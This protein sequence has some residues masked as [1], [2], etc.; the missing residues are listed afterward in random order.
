MG[1]FLHRE[2]DKVIE[3]KTVCPQGTYNDGGTCAKVPNTYT[4]KLNGNGATSGN[5][6][7]VS[8][9]T[10]EASC[11]VTLPKNGFSKNAYTFAKWNTKANGTGTSYKNAATIALNKNITLYAQ[12]TGDTYT[13]TYDSNGLGTPTVTNSCQVS[14]GK[15]SCTVPA[16]AA[17]V[18]TPEDKDFG[19]WNSSQD[20]SGDTNY[21]A[22]DPI[23]L[24]G[25]TTLYANWLGDTH[26]LTYNANGVN[27]LDVDDTCQVQG[28][29]DETECNV[30]AK[31]DNTFNPPEGKTFGVW[32]DN[33]AGIGETTYYPGDAI[34]LLDNNT[35]L[36]AIWIGS[37][38]TVT[39]NANEAGGTAPNDDTCIVYGTA[40]EDTCKVKAPSQGYL[41]TPTDPEK[42]F[43]GWNLVPAGTGTNYE[44][45]EEIPITADTT[46]YANWKGA[47]YT[48]TYKPNGVE[49]SNATDTC[50]VQGQANATTCTVTA[51]PDTTFAAPTDRLLIDWD[52]ES[53]G[54]GE[55]YDPGTGIITLSDNTTE[56]YAIWASTVPYV[57]NYDG[58]GVQGTPPQQ[59]ACTTYGPATA[60]TCDITIRENTFT[61][62]GTKTFDNWSTEP[63]GRSGNN[64]EAGAIVAL[65]STT[66]TIV[67]AN[68][69]GDTYNVT[70]GGNGSDGGT[71]PEAQSCT[72]QGQADN[73][74]CNITTRLN[75]FTTTSGRSFDHWNSAIDN[76]GTGADENASY[77]VGL[78]QTLYAI[79]TG[80]Q[81]TVGFDGNGATGTAPVDADCTVYGSVT[82]NTCNVEAPAPT[83]L[84]PPGGKTFAGWNTQD[85]GDGTNYAVPGSIP[86]S[87]TPGTSLY[88]NW[89]ATYAA[90][91][92]ANDATG[93][94]PNPLSCGVQ[95]VA[96][97]TCD[98]VAPEPTSLDTPQGR[99]FSGW[100][101]NQDGSG[102]VN[103]VNPTSIILNG[104]IILYAN[105][106]S[107]TSYSIT[108]DGNG[109][110]GS[111]PVSVCTLKGQ[112]NSTSCDVQ[113]AD[114]GGF[115]DP[116]TK[117]FNGWNEQPNGDGTNYGTGATIT[118]SSSI[119]LY[120][121]WQ[122][123]TYQATYHAN[124]ATPDLPP[125]PNGCTVHGEASATSCD[126]TAPNQGGL[127][128]P[129]GKT[130]GGW[131]LVQAGTG[132]NYGTG[133]TIT[134]SANIPLYA[135]WTGTFVATFDPNGASGDVPAPRDC[136]VQGLAN[137]SCNVQMPNHGTLEVTGKGFAGWNLY[138]DGS[139]TNHV[140]ST[141]LA[142][143]ES[144]TLFA[145]WVATYIVTYHSNNEQTQTATNSCQV[146][147]P[148]DVTTCDV[149]T[150]P[151]TTFSYSGNTFSTWYTNDS[152]TDGTP[153]AA[154]T[155]IPV[156][157]SM[158]LYA[159]WT[160]DSP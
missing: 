4:V 10:T 158:N 112:A 156:T 113:A 137:S 152:G 40:G 54:S 17:P 43:D 148:A 92:D 108:Y 16:Y 22:G 56:L 48:V 8:C 34:T 39:F 41:V 119:S 125:N 21:Q 36:Y 139:G 93:T 91:F 44:E 9:K 138:Q 142:L 134:L 84:T 153:Y 131:N 51:L 117:A 132:T 59:N 1:T 14:G 81:Y 32:N 116:G 45:E 97:A 107:E 150:L 86:L 159:I 55:D 66:P 73:T 15:T 128:N 37:A 83:D 82:A 111:A 99:A 46:L 25:D 13:A 133:A 126:V 146:K 114:Q 67:Y 118:L 71:E 151:D 27:E 74:V 147:G 85:D 53:D 95:G 90:T 135:N 12:W 35:L 77:D 52:V 24:S 101:P 129:A 87:S 145:N 89:T 96:S 3:A 28:V 78:T 124:G 50:T 136:A 80:P 130:F 7:S 58:N 5:T 70:Y 68:W 98:V 140:A 20:G 49:V 102:D 75:S 100:N 69:K 103:Y 72:V 19:G 2:Y 64:Y 62:P 109:A 106:L 157:A 155:S 110:Q 57:L 79:W 143:T 94:A 11:K 65:S 141:Y 33:S 76:T 122:G 18:T 61:P 38:Y 123:S 88:A 144:V 47:E 121:N 115:A 120:A 30:E 154:S 60:T 6:K 23:T 42:E 31:P 104:S 127:E 29:A 26:T 149:T 63:D 160:P 105:W